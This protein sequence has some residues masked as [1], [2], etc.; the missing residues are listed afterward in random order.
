MMTKI[1]KSV[2]MLIVVIFTGV[3]IYMLVYKLDPSRLRSLKFWSAQPAQEDN[4]D[5]N[6]EDLKKIEQL[7]TKG[8]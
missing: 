5:I 2:I 3:N 8:K 4:N 7:L 6:L 1:S